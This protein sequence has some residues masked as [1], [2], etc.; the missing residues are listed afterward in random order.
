MQPAQQV[1]DFLRRLA[2][3]RR[4]GSCCQQSS[5]FLPFCSFSSHV[6]DDA[7]SHNTKDRKRIKDI[8]AAYSLL[9]QRKRHFLS[10]KLLHDRAHVPPWKTFSPQAASVTKSLIHDMLNCAVLRVGGHTKHRTKTRRSRLFTL[11]PNMRGPKQKRKKRK[12]LKRSLV[13]KL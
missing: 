8:S 6:A 4:H 11:A 7:A 3:R 2:R 12:G 13:T 9:S 1:G 5:L 10:G